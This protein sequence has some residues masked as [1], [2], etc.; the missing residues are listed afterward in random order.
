MLCDSL[1]LWKTY[2]KGFSPLFQVAFPWIQKAI[3][4]TLPAER[5]DLQDGM[6]ALVQ[7][8]ETKSLEEAKF[9]NH[10]KFIDVHL[11]V[12]GVEWIY[13]TKAKNFLQIEKYS[14]K[15]DVEFFTAKPSPNIFSHLAIEP[16]I[17][18]IFWPGD[19]HLPCITP[20][21]DNKPQN[22]TKIVVKIPVNQ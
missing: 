15:N 11:V 10:R 12:Q 16:G 6:Y 4:G 14:D 9:E 5:Y 22:V 1:D 17:V 18:A 8:Y 7:K 13:W 3:K 21:T 20:Q 19:W 2:V